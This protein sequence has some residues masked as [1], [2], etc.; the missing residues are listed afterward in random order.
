MLI[1]YTSSQIETF[2]LKFLIVETTA[3][4][5][6]KGD[7]VLQS[8]TTTIKESCLT[9]QSITE[10]SCKSWM[11]RDFYLISSVSGGKEERKRMEI[12]RTRRFPTDSRN[13]SSVARSLHN[14]SYNPTS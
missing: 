8:L 14:L 3:Q 6:T 4:N 9:I 2:L 10:D 11:E 7:W 13:D 12:F 1:C 5:T